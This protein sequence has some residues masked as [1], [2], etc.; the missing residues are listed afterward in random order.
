MLNN[1]SPYETTD[2]ITEDRLTDPCAPTSEDR[3]Y[4]LMNVALSV[5]IWPGMLVAALLVMWWM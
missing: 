4:D 2:D 3:W 5:L 1:H